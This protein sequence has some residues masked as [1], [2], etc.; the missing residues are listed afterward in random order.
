MKEHVRIADY[1]LVGAA[2]FATRNTE[3]Y[4]VVVP[5][6]SNILENKRSTDL[7]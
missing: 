6:R 5:A 3:P 2:A 1:T 4:N 7:M